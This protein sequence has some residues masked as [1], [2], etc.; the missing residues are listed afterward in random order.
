MH[1]EVRSTGF[2]VD[3]AGENGPVERLLR[4]ESLLEYSY[5]HAR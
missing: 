1:P 4:L 3:T 5:S 2:T